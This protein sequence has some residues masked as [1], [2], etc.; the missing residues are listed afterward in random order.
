[1]SEPIARKFPFNVCHR[2]AMRVWLERACRGDHQSPESLAA[3]HEGG[4]RNDQHEREDAE[5]SEEV[6]LKEGAL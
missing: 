1:M 4:H 5:W 2:G 6:T 3:V